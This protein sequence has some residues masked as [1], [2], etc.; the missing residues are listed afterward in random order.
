MLIVVLV[1]FIVSA[2][3]LIGS[4][5]YFF[6]FSREKK[7]VRP[8][9][10]SYDECL[11]MYIQ[12]PTFGIQEYRKF[13]QGYD[14]LIRMARIGDTMNVEVWVYPDSNAVPSIYSYV[15]RGLTPGHDIAH[16]ID[17]VFEVT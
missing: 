3:I 5:I 11:I 16:F 17:R 1:V 4:G 15:A 2:T 12:V 14:T 10:V 8:T 7:I 9:Y 6:S 13:I